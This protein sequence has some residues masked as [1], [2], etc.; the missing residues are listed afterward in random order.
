LRRRTRDER[1][2]GEKEVEEEEKK[3]V[4]RS[5]SLSH[6]RLDLGCLSGTNRVG[7]RCDGGGGYLGNKVY[8]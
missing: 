5:S 3:M 6:R 4:D 8:P 1:E 7:R 2:K